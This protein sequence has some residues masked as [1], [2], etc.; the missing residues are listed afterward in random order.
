MPDLGVAGRPSDDEI[1]RLYAAVP[2]QPRRIAAVLAGHIERPG[3]WGPGRAANWADAVEAAQAVARA[4]RA[5][6][7]ARTAQCAPW[8]PG[9]CA[10]LLVGSTVVGHAGELHPRVI[11]TL[12]LPDGTCAMELDADAFTPPAP[13]PAPHLST[14]P[15]VLLDVALVVDAGVASAAVKSA[16]ATGAG[17]LLESVRLFDDFSDADKLG[18]GRKSLAFALRFRA[19]DRTLTLDEA[20]AMRDAAIARAADATGASLRT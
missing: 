19:P 12:G 17:A 7:E 4:A 14:Y 20:N 5:T 18:E 6:L 10:E 11:A 9:R 8:H 1:A 16:L 2:R 13:A 3:W 15:P